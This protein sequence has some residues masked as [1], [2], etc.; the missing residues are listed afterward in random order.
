MRA[1]VQGLDT[2]DSWNRYL[3]VEGE[4]DDI[5]NVKRTIQWIRDEFAAAA[6]R[7]ERHG[8]ARLIRIDA[9]NIDDAAEKIPSLEEFAFE[10]GLEDFSEAEQLEYFKTR[11]GSSRPQQSRRRRLIERQLEALR[12]LEALA[13]QPPQPDDHVGTWLNPDLAIHLEKAGLTTLRM[14]AQR[15]NGVGYRWAASIRAVGL[16]KSE[17]IVSWLRA[18]EATLGIAIGDH[19]LKRRSRLANAELATVIRPATAI[20]PLEKLIIPPDL[21]GRNGANRMPQSICRI[22]AT[23][24]LEA[25]YAW[26]HAKQKTQATDAQAHPTQAAA[27]PPRQPIALNHTQ[28]AYLKEAER[29]MLWALIERKKALSSMD[30]EDC[31]AYLDFLANPTPAELWCGARGREK[32]SPLWRPFEGPL[33]D[34][35]RRHAAT[36]LKSLYTFLTEQFYLK[37]NPWTGLQLPRSAT[38]NAGRNSERRLSAEQWRILRECLRSLPDSSANQRLQIALR[39]IEVTSLRLSEIV[40]L[41]VDDLSLVSTEGTWRLRATVSGQPKS[42]PIP[43]DVITDLSAYLL[44]R[45]LHADPLHP[46][47]QGACLLGKAIDIEQR[48]PWSSTH[49]K[50][51]NPRDGIA[52]GTLYDQIKA[53]FIDCAHAAEDK[54]V[55]KT[56]AAAS[57]GW[58]R[59]AAVQIA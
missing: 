56:L 12:W 26:L 49:R 6:R 23:R 55:A 36:V 24:D 44:A 50:T 19:V 38:A 16:G 4:H 10:Q 46:A 40:A 25:L 35:A 37:T 39:L 42:M 15:V 1:V 31:H 2:R 52:P 7:S 43:Q 30:R 17:R 54:A 33:S 47:N 48:A 58:L 13:V 3:R 32:W 14:L 41:R 57:T 34:S 59:H 53:F 29:F 8:I 51:V 5:R 18:H 28:R 11:Y 20:V 21:D 45:G 22:V 27:L 9:N